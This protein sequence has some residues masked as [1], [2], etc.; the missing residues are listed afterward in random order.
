LAS[1]INYVASL[2]DGGRHKQQN[3][4][5]S[6]QITFEIKPVKDLIINADLN[7]RLQ[8]YWQH[9][10]QHPTYAHYS[11]LGEYS[12]EETYAATLTGFSNEYV[13]LVAK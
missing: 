5:L 2:T 12:S 4:L 7:V 11:G 10:D 3:D 9:Y 13:S 8:D 6:Q 1:D